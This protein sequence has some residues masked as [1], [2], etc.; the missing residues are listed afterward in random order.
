MVDG[1]RNQLVFPEQTPELGHEGSLDKVQELQVGDKGEGNVQNSAGKREIV[2]EAAISQSKLVIVFQ[3][4]P[5]EKIP[6]D[7]W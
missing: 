2:P 3:I 4:Y 7:T 6:Q 5:V 1:G